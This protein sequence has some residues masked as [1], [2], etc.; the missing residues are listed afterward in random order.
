MEF[1]VPC[2]FGLEGPTADQLRRLGSDNVRA[3][4]GAV[5]FSGD[6][7]DMARANISLR[8]G[9]RVL[10]EL[11]SFEVLSFDDLFEAVLRL[12]WEDFIPRNGSFPVKGHSLNS[13]LFSVPACQSIIKKAVAE[14]LKK[15]YK[16]SVFPEDG[17]LFRIQ[18]MIMKDTATLYLDTS[19][20]GLHK[21][22]Y[23]PAH[24]NAPLRETLAAALVSFAKYRGK[25]S[26]ADPFCGSG[27][28]AIEAALAALNRAP[29]INRSF[30][31]EDW[32]CFEK[33]IW[34]DVREEA[35]A[36]EYSGSYEISA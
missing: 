28:I 30:S 20:A 10:I 18:F 36:A 4:N 26:F 6:G 34:S 27:T 24:V 32:G 1:C 13:K 19:G 5:R 15:T 9:E 7:T 2:L 21:R 23:R 29:G 35:A 33:R 8:C 3:S 12:P 17:A 14:R 25:G 16:L 11:G 31:A 22:G